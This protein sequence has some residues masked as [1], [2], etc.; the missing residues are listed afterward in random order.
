MASPWLP[1][2]TQVLLL[3]FLLLAGPTLWLQLRQ[4][5]AGPLPSVDGL[6]FTSQAGPL[7]M[8][9]VSTGLENPWSLAFLPDGRMLV[10][11]RPGRLRLLSAEG[12]LGEP[13]GGVPKVAARGQGGLLD[14]L[15]SP[16]FASTGL[17]Y[18][19]YSEPRG[20]DQNGTSVLRA[21]LK[22]SGLSGSL[23][24]TKVIFRQQPAVD[25]GHHFGSRLVWARDGTLFVSLGDRGSERD[26]AQTLD[27][28]L[29]KLLRIRADG[30]VPPDN[31]FVNRPGAKP[32]IWSYGHR[33]QQGAALHP[34]SGAIWTHEHGPQGGDEV[35]APKAGRNYGWPAITYGREYSGLEVGEGIHEHEGMEQPL[36]YW[37]PSI[38]PSG[39]AFYTHDRVPAWKGSLFVASLKLGQL[40]RLTLD[41]EKVV[42]EERL[43]EGLNRRLRD[44]RQGPDGAL[45]LLT[46]DAEGAILRLAPAL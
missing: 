33:N 6:R 40:S 37:V 20:G 46:D 43:L 38:A 10:T 32:E 7:V 45:Y 18:L 13:L 25:S 16:D 9:E 5:E 34:V 3:V 4:P 12:E 42:G 35:N 30:S 22:S 23:E 14:V 15:P 19:S 24:E 11:E 26:S 21:R 44:V 8:S 39:M 17:I 2:R 31:P 27:N 1:H 28:H 41:G 36:H 29:G